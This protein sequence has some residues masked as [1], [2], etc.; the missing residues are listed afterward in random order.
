MS[1]Q[2]VVVSVVPNTSSHML[3]EGSDA[4]LV[5]QADANPPALSFRW[6]FNQELKFPPNP[7]E[8]IIQNVSRRYHDS[9]VK[10][11]A[12]NTV[13]KSEDSQTLEVTCKW[14]HRNIT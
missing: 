3:I 4:K 10:C 7:Y 9:I 5:C 11:E 1:G 13:G 12:R 6:F 2:Q 8:F 14:T